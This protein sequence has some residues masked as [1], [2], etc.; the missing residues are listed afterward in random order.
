LNQSFEGWAY[1]NGL[2]RRLADLERQQLLERRNRTDRVYRLTT[3]GRIRALGGRDPEACWRRPWDGWW[4]LISYDVPVSQ[5]PRR[6]YLRHYLRSRKFGLLQRSLW[7]SPDPVETEADL[8]RKTDVNTR[9]LILLQARTCGGESNGQI[10]TAAWDFDR[11]NDLYLQ[12]MQIL[13]ERPTQKIKS[14]TQGGALLRWAQ[15]EQ[16]AWRNAVVT[17]PLLPESLLP[18]DYQGQR[19]WRNRV[20]KFA[21]IGERIKDWS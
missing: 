11:I 12:H 9:S 19:A 4:R 17:D 2:H 6:N 21:L 8:L 10:V 13:S 7:V 5:N 16:A 20:E 1:R 14:R 15:K 3:A 18:D